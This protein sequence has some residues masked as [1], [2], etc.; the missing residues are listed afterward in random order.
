MLKGNA[1]QKLAKFKRDE[2]QNLKGTVAGSVKES[3]VTKKG[4]VV[5]DVM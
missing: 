5:T 4:P 2:S 3:T 1:S